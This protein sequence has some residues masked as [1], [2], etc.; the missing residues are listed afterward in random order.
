[1]G[2]RMFS[3]ASLAALSGIEGRDLLVKNTF[4]GC[5]SFPSVTSSLVISGTESDTADCALVW[6]QA[7]RCLKG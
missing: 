3:A 1:M 2:E 7:P 4:D 6:L 5:F